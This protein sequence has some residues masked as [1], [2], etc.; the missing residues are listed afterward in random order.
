[1]Y[2][3]SLDKFLSIK[4]LYY[5]DIDYAF[6]PKLWK[7]IKNKIAINAKVIHIVGTNGKGTT[8][9]AISFCLSSINKKVGHYSSPELFSYNDMYTQNDKIIKKETLQKAHTLVYSLL[10][11]EEIKKISRFEYTTLLSF[12]IFKD[13]DYIVLEAGLGGEFDATNVLNKVLSVVT[14]ISLDHCAFLGDSIE[15]IA[16]TKIQSI[17]KNLLL[18]QQ[19]YKEVES[20]ASRIVSQRE[21]TL[22]LVNDVFSKENCTKIKLF[23]NTLSFPLFLQSN[24]FL[25]IAC[26]KLLN[27]EINLNILKSLNFKYRFESVLKNLIVDVGHNEAAALEIKNNIKDNTILVFNSYCDKN[28][29]ET[30]KI[31]KPK[32]KQIILLEVDDTR[33]CDINKLAVELEFT[34]IKIVLVS[35]DNMLSIQDDENYLVFGSFSLVKELS[36]RKVINK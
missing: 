26:M 12:E 15:S 2:R 10:N 34:N 14:P 25:A 24:L 30:I 35:K 19:Q 7:R 22:N 11:D 6:F 36:F 33:A 17:N 21:G 3:V 13:M 28:Y 23:L 16:N 4:P 20:I 32:L 8:G 31:L 9:K 5:E 29:K 27:Y 18:G 1:M